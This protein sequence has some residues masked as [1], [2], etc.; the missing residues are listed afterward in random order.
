MGSQRY[1]QTA[2]RKIK[3]KFLEKPRFHYLGPVTFAIKRIGLAI[4]LSPTAQAMLAEAGRLA[5][6]FQATLMLLHVGTEKPEAKQKIEE[7]IKIAGLSEEK[8][9]LLWRTGDPVK[10]IIRFS[11]DE[12][13]DLL[14][15]GALKKENLVNYYLG[16]VA[17]KIMRKAPCSLMMIVKP[18]QESKWLK[19]VV[20]N[21]EDSPFIKEALQ[22]ACHWSNLEP[23]ARVHVVRELKLLGL[24]LAASEQY[25]EEEYTDSKQEM[26]AEEVKVV[27][28][29]LDE[30]THD[31]VKINI[32][33]LSGKSGFELSQFAMRKE[34]DLLV[35][36]APSRRFSLFDR[37]FPHDQEYVFNDLP[38]N[39][40]VIKPRLK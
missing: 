19:N 38:C 14:L 32:K 7:L 21:A 10:E 20:V 37:I 31:H 22:A 30:I 12:K 8:I 17:R 5:T 39:L 6:H 34:A 27:E 33:L 18:S 29:M 15:A 40:L 35:M 13:I 23:G 4:A 25:S 2:T 36:G 24:A 1:W 16:T 3:Y 28:K 26:V 11:K 9:V